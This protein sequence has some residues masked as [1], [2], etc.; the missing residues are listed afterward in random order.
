MDLFLPARLVGVRSTTDSSCSAERWNPILDV[1]GKCGVKFALEVHPDGDRLRH[2]HG[3]SGAVKHGHREEFGFNY[4]PIALGLAGRR[5]GEVHP[6]VPRPHLPRAHEGRDGSRSTGGGHLGRPLNF[7]DPRRGW[8]FRSLGHGG[9]NFEEIIL[10]LNQI[11]YQGPLCVEWED[12][13]MD[14]NHGAKEACEFVRKVDF[15][16][17]GRAFDAAFDKEEQG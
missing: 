15:A 1:F 3:A 7:G 14:R 16:P 4:D 17:S 9:M 13:G 5:S 2:L 6:R 11:D 10:A 8:D 12:M